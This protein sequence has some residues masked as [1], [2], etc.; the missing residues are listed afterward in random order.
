[1]KKLFIVD[2]SGLLVSNYYGTLPSEVQMAKTQEEQEANYDKIAQRN[3]FYV[4]AIYPTIKQI[5]EYAIGLQADYIAV[6]F[7]K[8]RSTTFRKDLY[9]DYKGTRKK[10]PEPLKEQFILCEKLLMQMGM[11]VF[12]H[13]KYEADDIAGSIS[14]QFADKD[15][16]AIL[17]TKDKDY[18]QLVDDNSTVWM[19]LFKKEAADEK[20][21]KYKLTPSDGYVEYLPEKVVPFDS[22]T[23]VLEKGVLPQDFSQ[24]LALAGDTADN[25]PGVKG[26]SEETAAKLIA[27]YHTVQALYEDIDKHPT[28]KDIDELKAFWKDVLDIKR[29][30]YNAL[31][32]YRNEAFLSVQLAKIKEDID[33]NELMPSFDITDLLPTGFAA[34]KIKLNNQLTASVRSDI[35]EKINQLI[36]RKE[37]AREDEPR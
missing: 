6:C 5:C 22:K 32:N 23:V 20:L 35:Y 36:D 28:K 25:I 12:F 4:N 33:M 27:H 31:T 14:K 21:K 30:P 8:S 19:M 17:L 18:L 13:D 10:S 29:S 16:K 34:D 37:I 1:M 15:T 26:V 11:T 9:E 24:V 7:D 3:G 2:G